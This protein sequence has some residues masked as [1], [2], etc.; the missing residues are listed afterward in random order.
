MRRTWISGW[1]S[2]ASPRL[3]NA[4]AG[5][6]YQQLFPGYPFIISKMF[7]S[8]LYL[9]QD[10]SI[11]VISFRD[12]STQGESC[13]RYIQYSASILNRTYN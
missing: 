3:E 7:L 2:A 6:G 11:Q 12:V 8:K 1:F 4:P 13:T 9:F 5:G 10:V